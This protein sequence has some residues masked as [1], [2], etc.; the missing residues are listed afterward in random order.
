AILMIIF[1]ILEL[2]VVFALIEEAQVLDRAVAGLIMGAVAFAAAGAVSGA[3]GGFVLARSN[4]DLATRGFVWRSALAFGLVQGILVIPAFFV[5]LVAI[6][7]DQGLFERLLDTVLLGIFFGGIFGAFVSLLLAVLY[8]LHIHQLGRIVLS[9]ALGFAAGGALVSILIHFFPDLGIWPR[10]ILF[11]AVGGGALGHVFSRETPFDRQLEEPRVRHKWL[12]ILEIGL[13]IVVGI[14]ALYL[15]YNVVNAIR[16]NLVPLNEQVA[17]STTG[18]AW[19]EEAP[20]PVA[21]TNIN[22]PALFIDEEQRPYSAWVQ[23]DGGQSSLVY[24]R[25]TMPGSWTD[26][27]AVSPVSDPASADIQGAVSAEGVVHLLWSDGGTIQYSRCSD[28]SCSAT[29]NVSELVDDTCLASTAAAHQ[30][31]VIALDGD[32]KLTAVWQTDGGQLLYAAWSSPEQPQTAATGCVPAADGARDPQL[33]ALPDN[34][35]ALVFA[36]GDGQ[37]YQTQFTAEQWAAEPDLLG[38]GQFPSVAI[39]NQGLTH[40]AWCDTE[41]QVTYAGPSGSQ[42]VT[43]VGG[44]QSRPAL[45]Q[46]GQGVMHLLW[47][48]D[49][50]LNVAGGL[51][52]DQPHIMES[53][54]L[55]GGWTAPALVSTADPNVAPTLQADNDGSLHGLWSQD[56]A[57]DNTLVY[58]TQTPYECDS[59]PQ[60]TAG[61][62]MLQAVTHPTYLPPDLPPTHCGNRF[63]DIIFAAEALAEF[64]DKTPTEN[65][66]FDDMADLVQSAQYEVLIVNMKWDKSEGEDSPG[67]AVA[68]SIKQLYDQV[69]ADPAR[70]PRGVNVRIVLGNLPQM[71]P[72]SLDRQVYHILADLRDVGLPALVDE[73]LGWKVEIANYQ[74]SW[75]H[76]HVKM[77]V[78]DGRTVLGSGF[79]V[80][81]E[82]FSPQH[83]SGL[84]LGLIDFGLIFRGPVAQ[85]A[86]A[87][88]DD[89]WGA[90]KQINCS[91]QQP[92]LDLFWPLACQW[93]DPVVS[94]LPEVLKYD[95]QPDS[96][97]VAFSL[98]RSREFLGSDDALLAAI[99][100]AEES[101]DLFQVNFSLQLICGAGIVIPNLCTY[102]NNAPEYIQAVAD[103]VQEKRI[104]VRILT[105]QNSAQGYENRVAVRVLQDELEARGISDLVEIRFND[106]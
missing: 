90:S 101:I 70:Y 48:S 56:S 100:A 93:S 14:I 42:Q 35:V 21:A 16:V 38:E 66:V 59:P 20:P 44:C 78:I 55:S 53:V 82:H 45:A 60:T 102:E 49:Q 47:N 50:F 24:A 43:T 62:A 26:S 41:N 77:M 99:G 72:F 29:V 36:A 32:D 11:G 71:Q 91:T 84:G 54:L 5:A 63:E 13:A 87:V 92:G 106:G 103:V 40:F 37:I 25:Q 68:R 12:Q 6:Y 69:Q 95:V 22:L 98:Y 97:D 10:L 39:D 86:V 96:D 75:P 64:S 105:D 15:A 52:N 81:Y 9:G 8:R 79:N 23:T 19:V 28:A 3:A 61:A 83:P 7:F 85:S 34:N 17:Q 76:S 58:N 89:I 33:A 94:H 30:Q 104:P 88:F 67:L 46:D 74:G 65:S 27:I 4:H 57:G 51:V 80:A 73:D 1:G 18:A 2:V 31:P